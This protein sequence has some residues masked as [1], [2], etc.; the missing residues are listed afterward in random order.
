M[1][2][3]LISII[4]DIT[5]PSNNPLNKKKMRQL[6]IL[7]ALCRIPMKQIRKLVADCG[8]ENE[9]KARNLA[10]PGFAAFWIIQAGISL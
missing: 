9:S 4:Q 5:E 6:K 3:I 10:A 7:P 1:L 8:H 2:F